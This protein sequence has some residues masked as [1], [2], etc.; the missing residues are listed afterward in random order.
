MSA[1]DVERWGQRGL[2]LPGPGTYVVDHKT[3]GKWSE[4]NYE[5]QLLDSY[6]FIVYPELV[7]HFIDEKIFDLPPVQG[8]I[9]NTIVSHKDPKFHWCFSTRQPWIM[10]VIRRD[11]GI[12]Q[13]RLDRSEKNSAACYGQWGKPCFALTNGKCERTKC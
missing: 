1:E 13:A 8:M 11:F 12:A 4:E 9:G 2:R 7:Q 10:D 6:Q 3:T 5:Q